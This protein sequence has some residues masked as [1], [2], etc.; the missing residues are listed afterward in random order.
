MII[1]IFVKQKI[2]KKWKLKNVTNYN[3]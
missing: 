1:G 3:I 2:D